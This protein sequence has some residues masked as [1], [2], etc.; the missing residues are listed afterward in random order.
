MIADFTHT[1]APG[2]SK[3]EE[4]SKG[5]PPTDLGTLFADTALQH[6][7]LAKLVDVAVALERGEAGLVAA[8][9]VNNFQP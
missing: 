1:Q 2:G 7:L 6:Q 8:D 4:S 9:P 3:D 5:C